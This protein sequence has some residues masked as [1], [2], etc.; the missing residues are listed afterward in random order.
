MTAA[1]LSSPASPPPRRRR[2]RRP[3]RLGVLALVAG[4]LVALGVWTTYHRLSTPT[5]PVASRPG[6]SR[7]AAPASY[8]RL[9]VQLAHIAARRGHPGPGWSVAA[10]GVRVVPR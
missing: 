4:L 9:Y 5:A 6:A 1:P 7:S 8:S 2:T 3:I 10:V